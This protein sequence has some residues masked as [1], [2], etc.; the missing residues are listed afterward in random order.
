MNSDP[1]RSRFMPPHSPL[2]IFALLMACVCF[3]G[4]ATYHSPRALSTEERAVV[5]SAGFTNLT[6]GIVADNQT[7]PAHREGSVKLLQRTR[8]FKEVNLAENLA[9]SPDLS[10]RVKPIGSR[11][12]CLTGPASVV[13]PT[14][15]L[16]PI[17]LS[18]D[19]SAD[20]EIMSPD[21]SR[22]IVINY[23]SKEPMW[24]GSSTSLL[25]L[26]PKWTLNEPDEE[27]HAQ[28]LAWALA[29]KR[30]RIRA[31]LPH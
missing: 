17:K 3:G 2:R 14:L 27:R 26:S 18:H 10:I 22:T 28:R 24:W 6:V 21:A 25:A 15:G 19:T 29:S 5:A 30:D 4:C 1:L 23:Q 7:S 11:L 20:F 13:I 16:L 9:G 31:L 8:L 12:W